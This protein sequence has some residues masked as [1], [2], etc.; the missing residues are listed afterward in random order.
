[1]RYLHSP[2][3]ELDEAET[4]PGRF[5]KYYLPKGPVGLDAEVE[6]ETAALDHHDLDGE[7]LV[8]EPET[9]S[10]S[11]VTPREAAVLHALETP[12]TIGWLE[13]NW[14]ADARSGAAWFGSRVSTASIRPC[15]RTP[16]MSRRDGWSSCCSPKNAI[17]PAA[18]V[19]PVPI[20]RCRI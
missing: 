17:S 16:L 12:R 14:P 6:I 4:L 15:S 2:N 8:V 18:I 20:R 19:W 5:G 11:F 10:W 7:R 13:A 9:V 1:M 3:I